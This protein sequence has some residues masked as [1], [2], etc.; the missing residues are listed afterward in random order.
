MFFLDYLL[1]KYHYHLSII[2]RLSI[3]YSKKVIFKLRK[4]GTRRNTTNPQSTPQKPSG[5]LLKSFLG[6]PF[7]SKT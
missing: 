7:N 2:Y 6:I 4:R 3:H 1:K 5:Y